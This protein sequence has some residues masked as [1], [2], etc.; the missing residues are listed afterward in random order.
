MKEGVKR[1]LDQSLKSEWGDLDRLLDRSLI[2]QPGVMSRL[3]LKRMLLDHRS[4]GIS[5][6]NNILLL[7]VERHCTG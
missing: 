1:Y 3:K 5:L 6:R 2:K 4:L 7:D